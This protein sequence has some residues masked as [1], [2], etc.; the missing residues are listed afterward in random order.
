MEDR[1]DWE[2]LASAAC[3]DASSYLGRAACRVADCLSPLLSENPRES[4]LSYL[5]RCC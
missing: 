4:T 3:W 5:E 2:E 1:D